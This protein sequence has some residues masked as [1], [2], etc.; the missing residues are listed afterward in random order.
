MS[1]R[2]RM[3]L[4]SPLSEGGGKV[5][6]RGRCRACGLQVQA[7]DPYTVADLLAAHVREAHGGVS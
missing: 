2:R 7:A 4:G 3:G 6:Y 1:A 5:K